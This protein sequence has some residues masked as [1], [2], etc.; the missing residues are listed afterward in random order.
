MEIS[1]EEDKEEAVTL[2]KEVSISFSLSLSS[3]SNSK[4]EYSKN[5]APKS[6]ISSD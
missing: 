6:L 5:P 4:F 2:P 3:L 1:G